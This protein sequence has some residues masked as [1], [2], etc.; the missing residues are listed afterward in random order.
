[1]RTTIPGKEVRF[2][3]PQN[4]TLKWGKKQPEDI[5]FFNVID[6]A[7]EALS[8]LFLTLDLWKAQNIYFSISRRLHNIMNEKAS[9]GDES[10]QEWME[11]FHKLG[12]YLH[13]KI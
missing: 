7:M 11:A 6:Q 12:G 9:T 3:S 8:P 10:A 2:L 5:N 1:M 4:S 13:V